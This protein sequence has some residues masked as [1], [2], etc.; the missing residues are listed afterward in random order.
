MKNRRRTG[1]TLVELLV[2]IGIVGLVLALVLPAIQAAR[3]TQRRNLCRNNLRQIG[4]AL[5]G[6]EAGLQLRSTENG[7]RRRPSASARDDPIR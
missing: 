2:V 1:V 3:E 6:Y 7:A 5:H 4:L